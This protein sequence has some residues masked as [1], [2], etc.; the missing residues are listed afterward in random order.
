MKRFILRIPF[1]F[2][3][4]QQVR[5]GIKPLLIVL[6]RMDKW[7]K[8]YRSQAEWDDHNCGV[9]RQRRGIFIGWLYVGIEGIP[10][11]VAS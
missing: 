8:P 4:D 3:H 9:R 1:S 7:W 11:R 10:V 2:D 6:A 5:W